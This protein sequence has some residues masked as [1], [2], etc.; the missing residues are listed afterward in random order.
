[1]GFFF[2]QIIEYAMENFQYFARVWNFAPQE[3]VGRHRNMRIDNLIIHKCIWH[4]I[5]T[6]QHNLLPVYNRI[7]THCNNAQWLMRRKSVQFVA[8][9]MW[10]YGI[11]DSV[12]NILCC[13]CTVGSIHSSVLMRHKLLKKCRIYSRNKSTVQHPKL[14]QGNHCSLSIADSTSTHDLPTK[15]KKKPLNCCTF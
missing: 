5:C 12:H 11:R 13:L 8:Q 9:I 7:S 4:P 15:K 2:Q 6:Q 10:E 3:K 1:M 14:W